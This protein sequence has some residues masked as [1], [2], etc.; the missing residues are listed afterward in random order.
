MEADEYCRNLLGGSLKE[1]EYDMI[2]EDGKKVKCKGGW[3]IVD[4]GMPQSSVF[5]NP[6]HER[7]SHDAIHWSE[8]LESIRKD[9]ECTFGILK[10]RFRILLNRLEFHD[11]YVIEAILHTCCILHNML[12]FGMEKI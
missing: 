7:L 12:L 3:V 9:V 11:R 4:G 8:W 10:Q 2:L 1:Y 6:M 5:I